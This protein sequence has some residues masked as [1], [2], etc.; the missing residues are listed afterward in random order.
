MPPSV[1]ALIAARLDL[2]AP[3]ERALLQRGAVVGDLFGRAVLLELGG[4][5]GWLSALDEKGFLRRRRDGFR[6]HHALV[7]DVAYASLPKAERAEL[8][9]RLADWLEGAR[10]EADEL[11]G[12]HLEQA[13]RF[14]PSSRRVDRRLRGLAADAGRRLG[15]AG[16]DGLE[17]RRDGGNG[18]PARAGDGAAPGARRLPARASLRARHRAYAREASSRGLKRLSSAWPKPRRRPATGASSCARG[19]SSPT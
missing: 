3:E 9:E 8:H 18:Q 11:V 16:I 17:A 12:Y 4:E 1:E 2:L 15:A 10:R 13:Y 6:F 5:V 19:S 14:A 7:R